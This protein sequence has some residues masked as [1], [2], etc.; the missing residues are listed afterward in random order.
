MLCG[1]ARFSKR[2][3]VATCTFFAVALLTAQLFPAALPLS[4]AAASSPVLSLSTIALLQLP[5]LGYTLAPRV[6]H[7]SK[8]A[9]LLSSFLLGVHFAF[10]LALAGMTAPSKVLSFFYLPLSFLPQAQAGRAW[11]PSLLMVALGGLVPNMV[12][13][14]QVKS[15]KK[16]LH[17]KEWEL[18]TRRDV[19]WKLVGGSAMFGVG[20][21]EPVV[22]AARAEV[23]RADFAGTTGLLGICPGPMLTVLGA[24]KSLE[25]VA[26]FFASFAVGGLVGGLVQ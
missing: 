7:S 9:E 3:F 14:S 22:R 21:G 16:P 24:G 6:I 13:W 19:D 10:G 18:P 5:F 26:P 20:W 23:A 1:L 25:I 12:A 11:D 8:S 17:K 4:I 15:W 2:S